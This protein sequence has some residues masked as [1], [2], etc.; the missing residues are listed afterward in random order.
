MS[1]SVNCPKTPI[2]DHK[3]GKNDKYKYFSVSFN[4][5]KLRRYVSK[6]I[7][8]TK[9]SCYNIWMEKTYFTEGRQPQ[10]V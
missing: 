3:Y 2:F 6:I 8:I 4:D 5:N 7:D 1:I 10:N 9:K